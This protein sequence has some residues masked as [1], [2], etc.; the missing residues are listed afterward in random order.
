[1][2]LSD[3]EKM[4]FEKSCK[5]HP[6]KRD[7][8]K[9]YSLVKKGK[10]KRALEIGTGDWLYSLCMALGGAWVVTLNEKP[11]SPAWF[12]ILNS[13]QDKVFQVIE[14]PRHYLSSRENLWDIIVINTAVTEGDIEQISKKFSSYLVSFQAD[15]MYIMEGKSETA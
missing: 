2:Q 14:K 4:L 6:H 5:S 11:S 7:A 15:D 3:K 13:Y 10:L 9:L 1:M 8:M 12:G